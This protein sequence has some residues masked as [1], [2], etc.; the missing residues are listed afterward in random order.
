MRELFACSSSSSSRSVAPQGSP[1]VLGELLV[2]AGYLCHGEE[3]VRDVR[4]ECVQVK[5][6]PTPQL[7]LLVPQ[8]HGHHVAE[9]LVAPFLCWSPGIL[10]LHEVVQRSQWALLAG[11]AR[12]PA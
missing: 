10:V 3:G 7:L 5:V 4:E 12:I 6:L 9:E 1:T 8:K 2:G 11:S